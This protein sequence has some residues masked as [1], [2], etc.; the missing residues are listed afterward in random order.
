MRII[1]IFF[2]KIF[3]PWI[4]GEKRLKLLQRQQF[5]KGIHLGHIPVRR[6]EAEGAPNKGNTGLHGGFVVTLGVAD[7]HRVG[8]S[9]PGH[10]GADG[11]A[12][13][14]AG[15]AKAQVAGNVGLQTQ[16]FHAELGIAALA[17]ADDEDP[18]EFNKL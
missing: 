9:M 8:D 16:L 12:L 14:G 2:L 1:C 15:I 3:L 10:Q 7:I 5:F 13:A 17:V 11:L 6:A 18:V 4:S